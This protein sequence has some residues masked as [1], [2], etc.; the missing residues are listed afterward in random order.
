ME[1]YVRETSYEKG[2]LLHGEGAGCERIF[3]VREGRI[4]LFRTSSSG[5]EQ[6][7][8]TLGPGETCACNPG[9]AVWYCGST[10][11]AL[12]PCKIWYLSRADY[13]QLVKTN[14]KIGHTLNELFARRLQ[15]LSALVEEVSLKDVKKR[16]VK[17]LIDMLIEKGR[18]GG[19][20]NVLFIPFTRQEIAQRLGAA[21]ETVA[22]YLSQLKEAHLIDIKPYQIIIL[23]KEGLQHLLD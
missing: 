6:I 21:R 11:Q 3:I 4:K 7:L 15:C 14:A 10:A 20:E 18:R 5:R 13:I 17:F 2:E 16:L 9:S 12:T 19:P 1:S 22:R 8:E 23:N